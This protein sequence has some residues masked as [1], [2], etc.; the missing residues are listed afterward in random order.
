M[1]QFQLRMKVVYNL[2]GA[3]FLTLAIVGIILPV[4]PTTPFLLLSAALFYKGSDRYYRWLMNHP[5]LGP[6]IENYRKYKAIPLSTKIF[7]VSLLWITILISAFLVLE[8]LWLRI[9]LLFIALGVS[10]HI[11]SFKTLHKTETVSEQGTGKGQNVEKGKANDN[12][13][14][15]DNV[16]DNKNEN[17]KYKGSGKIESRE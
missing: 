17:I 4:L 8:I 9:L 12:V 6:Y 14:I 13:D 7:S 5:R 1:L 16:N 10:I 15:N 3:L 11:L 2:L